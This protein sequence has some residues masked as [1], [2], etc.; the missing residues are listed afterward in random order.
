MQNQTPR[1]EPPGAG[2]PWYQHLAVKYYIGPFVAGRAQVK[3]SRRSFEILHEKI[4][5]LAREIPADQFDE[6]VIVPPQMGLEDSSRYW[7]AAMTLEHLLIVGEGMKHIIRELS[8]GRSPGLNATTAQVK[9]KGASQR[10]Q[11]LQH[12]EVFTR[13]TM[14]K[15]EPLVAGKD[16]IV[17]ENHPWFGAFRARQWF[18]LFGV[19]AGIHYKQLKKIRAGLAR[20]RL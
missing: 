17:T 7:S 4:L 10:E 16:S 2:L 18:W 3:E 14:D 13:T 9:P 1:L 5:N 8:A 15:M 12:F 19:H 20:A 11:L 6:K